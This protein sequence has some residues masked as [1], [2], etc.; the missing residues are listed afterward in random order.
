MQHV[1]CN[2]VIWCNLLGVV[3]L[4][5]FRMYSKTTG[6]E[7]NVVFNFSYKIT[8]FLTAT[9]R[10]WDYLQQSFQI[11]IPLA[12]TNKDYVGFIK[13]Q[14]PRWTKGPICSQ[15][16]HSIEEVKWSWKYICNGILLA[17]I[18]F[19]SQRVTCFTWNKLAQSVNGYRVIDG[20]PLNCDSFLVMCDLK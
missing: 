1:C 3:H 11:W 6:K 15:Q 10:K 20:L 17:N 12:I 5:L 7:N 18:L 2:W 4:C 13:H 8:G 19:K 9:G 14:L 16:V